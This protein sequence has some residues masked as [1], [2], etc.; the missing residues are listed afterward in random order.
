MNAVNRSKNSKG[1]H[2]KRSST[3]MVKKDNTYVPL[4]TPNRASTKQARGDSR[5]GSA[6]RRKSSASR[7]VT[8]PMA[9]ESSAASIRSR[10]NSA[11]RIQALKM[12]QVDKQLSDVKVTYKILSKKV[13]K[14]NM[15]ALEHLMPI[16]GDHG[17]SHIN[18]HAAHQIWIQK[19]QRV[20]R[21]LNKHG[22]TEAV[23]MQNE[24]KRNKRQIQDLMRENLFELDINQHEQQLLIGQQS[25]KK[26]LNRKLKSEP[27]YRRVQ[28]LELLVRE[29]M[30][31]NVQLNTWGLNSVVT[32][33]KLKIR[34]T[35]DVIDCAQRL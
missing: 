34:L 2:Q 5:Q 20:W 1:T 35:E 7:T 10:S 13:N 31:R 26:R 6:M 16:N 29:E 28:E 23:R 12:A 25:Y 19:I 17:M 27:E 33:V 14:N 30:A 8:K 32:E 9:R 15:R 24:I 3:M 4:K 11:E 22:N 18:S 21:R